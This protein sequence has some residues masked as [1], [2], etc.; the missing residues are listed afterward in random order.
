MA[1]R[2]YDDALIAKFK[3][4]LPEESNVRILDPDE[5]K[6]L[7]ELKAE[8]NNDQPITLPFI[9]LSR[10]N[11]V[12]LLLNIKNERS[13]SGLKL[14]SI[15]NKSDSTTATAQWNYIPIKLVYRLDI[16]AKTAEDAEEYLRN[17]LFK[18]INN[19]TLIMGIPYNNL[20]LQHHFNIRVQNQVSETSSIGER[21]FNGQF[22]RWTIPFEIQDAFLF[23]IPYRKNWTLD[24]ITLETYENTKY[25]PETK[26]VEWVYRKEDYK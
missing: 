2:F 23:N 13:F 20:M 22:H 24:G 6:K 11:D 5:T 25:P 21:L 9:A 16:Y 7:F 15:E 3:R 18:L 10:N 26:H 1:I 4:W 17:F 12:E 8:D 19:P 14:F